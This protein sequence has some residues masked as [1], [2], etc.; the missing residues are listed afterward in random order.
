M[1]K[2]LNALKKLGALKALG[3]LGSA[4]GGR[5]FWWSALGIR[6]FNSPA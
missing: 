4:R 6:N 2:I 1:L 5:N 3:P